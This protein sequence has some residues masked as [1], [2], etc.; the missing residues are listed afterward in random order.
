[1]GDGG[2]SSDD[3]LDRLRTLAQQQLT[4]IQANATLYEAET[5]R[6]VAILEESKAIKQLEVTTVIEANRNVIAR[7]EAQIHLFT[8]RVTQIIEMAR[9][10]ASSLQAI[11]TIASN[12][13]AGALAGTHVGAQVGASA[14][15]G[16][17]K[18]ATTSSAQN[19]AES[20]SAGTSYSVNHQ[21]NH[22][23]T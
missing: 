3:H 4:V 16:E 13:A 9:I 21:Y 12:L 1:M 14:S 23:A 15:S 11:G 17:A 7:Y 6:S 10:N 18:Q 22:D 20:L 19:R 8:A 5:R 2:G